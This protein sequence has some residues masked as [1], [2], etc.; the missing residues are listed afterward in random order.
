MVMA[1][2]IT[3]AFS[4]W[5]LREAQQAKRLVRSCL[6]TWSL[7]YFRQEVDWQS[8]LLQKNSFVEHISG[9]GE[10]LYFFLPLLFFFFF[11][12]WDEI[13]SHCIIL[14]DFWAYQPPMSASCI[15]ELQEYAASHK[16]VGEQSIKETEILDSGHQKVTCK[17]REA[18]G[19]DR[20]Q[21]PF[22]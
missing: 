9:E 11:T 4:S 2:M 1:S 14:A 21:Q 10:V 5:S 19:A 16:G 6:L 20:R 15:P 8:V 7:Q 17:I 12:F 3:S 18:K 13:S 22:Y